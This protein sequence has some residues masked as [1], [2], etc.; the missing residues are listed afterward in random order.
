MKRSDALILI[1]NQLD[2]LNGTFQGFRSDFSSEELSKA[3]VILTTLE[4]CGMAPPIIQ[5]R[6]FL[7][8]DNGEMVYECRE[9]ED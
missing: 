4:H 3:S 5:E 1:A 9:W 2:F 6:S 8:K 7:I